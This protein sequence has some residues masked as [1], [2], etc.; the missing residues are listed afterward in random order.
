MQKAYIFFVSSGERYLFNFI[1]RI[2]PVYAAKYT[3]QLSANNFEKAIAREMTLGKNWNV[4][5]AICQ[6]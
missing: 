3:C 4:D 2:F 5:K 1:K 6:E